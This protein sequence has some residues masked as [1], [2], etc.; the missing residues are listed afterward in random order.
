MAVIKRNTLKL[1]REK[2]DTSHTKGTNMRQLT[3]VGKNI[4]KAGE[5]KICHPRILYPVKCLSKTK[6]K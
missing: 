6:A 4:F 1:G 2:K 3:T 5:E